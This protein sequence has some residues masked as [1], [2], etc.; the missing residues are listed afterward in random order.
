MSSAFEVPALP[1][2][3]TLASALTHGRIH[4]SI[5]GPLVDAAMRSPDF[6]PDDFDLFVATANAECIGID[7]GRPAGGPLKLPEPGDDLDPTALY[8]QEIGRTRLLCA[9]EEVALGIG[10][11]HGEDGARRRMIL[12]NLRLVVKMAGAYRNRGLPLLDLIE[13]GNLGLIAAVDRFDPRR[14]F[15][16]STYASWWIRQAMV[17]AIARQGRT[18]RVPLHVMQGIHRLLIADRRLTH[19]LGRLPRVEELAKATGERV[20]S[21]ERARRAAS[22]VYSY[23]SEPGSAPLDALIDHEGPDRPPSP[24]EL[25]E[26][27]LEQERLSRLVGQLG[28]KEEAVLRIRYGFLDG[29]S[30]TLAETGEFLGVSRERTRQIEKRALSKLR[31]LMRGGQGGNGRGANSHAGNGNGAN[32]N[33]GNGHG[34]N[35]HGGNGHGAGRRAPRAAPVPPLRLATLPKVKV[36][37]GRGRVVASKV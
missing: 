18:V 35:G 11:Q 21:I 14:G 1:V 28:S 8:F 30:H 19:R 3:S 27:G 5:P 2:S 37:G 10:I 20:E 36:S 29:R 23:D 7:W 16:F 26:I 24:A 32:G 31:D 4:G 9:Q 12:A 6:D 15:R 25:V 13:E 22:T 33:G 17:R 34:G